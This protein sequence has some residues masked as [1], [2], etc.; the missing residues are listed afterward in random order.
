MFYNAVIC[1]KDADGMADSANPD[2]TAPER[3]VRS[4]SAL[5]AAP[6]YLEK[7]YY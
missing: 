2:Q 1:P 7:F 3:A 4:G 6:S 5:S